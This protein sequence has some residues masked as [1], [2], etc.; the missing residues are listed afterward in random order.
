MNVYKNR[1]LNVVR[2]L[3]E[4]PNPDQ[5]KM[6][7]YGQKT[8]I[9]ESGWFR[10]EQSCGTPCCAFGHY[11]HRQDLQC[12][13][14]LTEDGQIG[15]DHTTIQWDNEIVAIHF[16]ISRDEACKLF[17]AQGCND[18][19]SPEEAIAFIK[20]FINEKWPD[21]PVQTQAPEMNKLK[22][23]LGCEGENG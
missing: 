2:A 7:K 1:L 10:K 3:Q 22:E 6:L 18:A 16:G 20:K 12:T 11:A 4:S 14:H 9:K 17:A 15:F 21:E 5:F 8:I 13:F 23:L 19:Q